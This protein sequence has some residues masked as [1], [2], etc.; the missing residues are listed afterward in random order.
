MVQQKEN[1]I[2]KPKFLS[3]LPTP[4][5]S[6]SSPPAQRETWEKNMLALALNS[7]SDNGNGQKKEY[8]LK[9]TLLFTI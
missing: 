2:D 1:K 7:F 8:L 5:S 3:Q 6:A 9:N 4:S